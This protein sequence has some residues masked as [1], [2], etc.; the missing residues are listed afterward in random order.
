[1]QNYK[2]NYNSLSYSE[3]LRHAKI[4]AT[5]ELE[6]ALLSAA[7]YFQMEVESLEQSSQGDGW[8]PYCD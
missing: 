6:K 4:D 8:C 7:L 2:V 1:M 3:L 5:T